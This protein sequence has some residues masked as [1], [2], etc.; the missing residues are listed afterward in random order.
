[1]YK[2]NDLKNQNYVDNL[3]ICLNE[4]Y[5]EVEFFDGVRLDPESIPEGKHTYH[6]RHADDDMSQP[7]TIAPEGEMILINFC[8]TIVVDKK[9]DI[10]E[11]TEI[12]DVNWL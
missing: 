9:F 6:T 12:Q 2:Y 3:E 8:G 10:K 4:E 1:M 5:Y 7:V 11:E